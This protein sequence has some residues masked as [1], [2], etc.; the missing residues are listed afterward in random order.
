MK[1]R[2]KDSRKRTGKRGLCLLTA[3]FLAAGIL[4]TAPVPGSAAA[5]QPDL[6]RTDGSIVFEP[7][8][9]GSDYA[10]ELEKADIVYDVYR[11]AE[12][13]AG[14]AAGRYTYRFLEPYQPLEAEYRK[15][16]DNDGWAELAQ[17]AMAIAI[18]G[19]EAPV[20]EGVTEAKELGCGLYLVITRSAKNRQGD[21]LHYTDSDSYVVKGENA[22]GTPRLDSVVEAGDNAYAF[23]PVLVSLPGLEPGEGEEDSGEWLY[24]LT[25]DMKPEQVRYGYLKLIKNLESFETHDPATFVFEIRAVTGGEDGSPEQVVY[26]DVVTITFTEPGQQ[27]LLVGPI[28]V[29]ARVTVTEVYSGISYTQ[30]SAPSEPVVIEA[31]R[32]AEYPFTNRYEGRNSH[33]GAIVNH[34]EYQSGDWKWTQIEG[35]TSTGAEASAGEDGGR[36]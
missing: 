21:V 5:K 24:R 27:S 29:G 12:A 7:A 15:G 26:S 14:S 11:I 33:G 22:D 10:A 20:R 13:E 35:G 18:S 32:I 1:M 30:V 25:V 6:T 23:A 17:K 8:A 31:G 9:P 28:P 4:G 3:L 2:Q 19:G 34:F 36:Q 16:L